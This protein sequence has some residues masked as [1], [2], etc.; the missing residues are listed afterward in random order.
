M[1]TYVWETYLQ[2]HRRTEVR[3]HYSTIRLHTLTHH[4]PA[5][6]MPNPLATG[7]IHL[8]FPSHP[9]PSSYAPLS[10]FRPSDFPLGVIGI[11]TCSQ[12]D[13]LSSILAHFNAAMSDLFPAGSTYPLASNCFVFEDSDDNTNLNLGNSLS[14]LVVI[15]SMMGN[16]KIYIG[17]LIADL[18]SNIL[19]GFA[20]LVRSAYCTIECL[21]SGHPGTNT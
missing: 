3:H 12:N 16:K 1:I 13:S 14:G 9:L 11:A 4:L 8:A 10:L 17:T 15:P 20:T 19:G 5:R 2:I 21:L 7:H 18:C 6:F